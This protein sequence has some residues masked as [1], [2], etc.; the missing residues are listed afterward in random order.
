LH[1]KVLLL[2][3]LK[4]FIATLLCDQQGFG[5]SSAL[6]SHF[7]GILQVSDQEVSL[8]H[9]FRTFVPVDI[10]RDCLCDVHLS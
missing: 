8:D 2:D 4:D 9:L 3:G 7:S 6:E 1:G 5:G 10:L